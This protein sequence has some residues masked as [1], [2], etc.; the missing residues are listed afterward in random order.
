MTVYICQDSLEGILC[1]VFDAWAEGKRQDEIRLELEG[2]AEPLLFTEYRSVSVSVDKAEQ[3]G[4]AVRSRI[5]A[6]AFEKICIAALSRDQD[7]ADKIYRFLTLGLQYGRNVMDM[8]S[9]PPVFHL[10]QLWRAVSNESRKWMEFI[11]FSETRER[12]LLSRIKPENAVLP[13]LA[14]HFSDRMPEETWMIMDEGRKQALI[15]MPE[16]RW[17]IWKI[18]EKAE[19]AMGKWETDK[20]DYENLWRIFHREIAIKERTNLPCQKTHLPLK[21]R[22]NMTEFLEGS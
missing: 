6:D 16:R 12:L 19:K 13:L 15:G 2:C 17:F 5:C 8:L 21:Y 1:G 22:E 11:R 18:D 20:G 9:A 14:P 10:F 7:K 3:A 4:K